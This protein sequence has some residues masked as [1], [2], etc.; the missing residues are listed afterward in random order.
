V[1]SA[2]W[3]LFAVGIVLIL[4]GSLM[5][6]WPGSGGRGRVIHA[7]MRDDDIIEE[8][9]NAQRVPVS[10]WVLMAG[11]LCLLVSVCWRLVRWFAA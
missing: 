7:D 6:G 9:N 10:G 2:P 4:I 11:F 3:Y 1:I 5:S 8:L